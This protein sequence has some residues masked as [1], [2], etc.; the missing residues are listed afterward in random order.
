MAIIPRQKAKTQAN[1]P[2]ICRKQS[3]WSSKQS[4]K[5]LRLIRESKIS[6]CFTC[7]SRI[8]FVEWTRNKDYI[9][10]G[11]AKNTRK[12][13]KLFRRDQEFSGARFARSRL[14][15]KIA[16]YRRVCAARMRNCAIGKV[17]ACVTATMIPNRRNAVPCLGR[18]T[19]FHQRDSGFSAMSTI[20]QWC[21]G[22][23]RFLHNLKI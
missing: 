10:I 7:D 11:G 1:I 23:V 16:T 19:Y 6:T 2:F 20:F 15:R 21:S 18:I 5:N 14:R 17:C 8:I 4:S 22:P 3:L 12:V 9:L 13:S